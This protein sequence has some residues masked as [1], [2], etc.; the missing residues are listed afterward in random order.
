MLRV[1][2]LLAAAALAAI[3]P[4]LAAQTPAAV[5]LS[6]FA[7]VSYTSSNH[8]VGDVVVG[9]LYDRF[10]DQFMLNAL[11]VVLDK[12]YDASQRSAGFHA[13]AVFGQNASVIQSNGLTLGPQGDLTQLYVT[14]NLPT[15]SG[16]GVQLRAGKIPSLMGLEV[17]ETQANPN[18]SEGLQFIYV[19][20][21]TGLGLAVETK[22]S[23]KV[24]A[25]LR[26]MN[27]WDLV[28]ETNR[29][30][31]FMARIGIYP[32]AQTSIGVLG[33]WGPEQ[34]GNAGDRRSGVEVL[35][36]RKLGKTSLWVQGDFGTEEGIDAQWSALG[37][38]LAQ[39][40]SGTLNVAL[41]ADYL[42]DGD[43]A[44]TSGALGFP[45]NAGHDLYSLTATL[46]V[47]AWP[48]ALV[49]PELRYDHSSLASF[50][51]EQSQVSLGLSIAYLF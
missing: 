6:G 3:V 21:F 30:K 29:G 25:Q 17:I 40:L 51:G 7:E 18:W 9:R 39:D 12:P 47:R 10:H 28:R 34:G 27:G 41:R 19:E 42:H 37:A 44:R 16:N 13:Q 23:D 38:W 31:S 20:N 5:K 49:R 11:G 35:V 36:F 24:D 33:F 22:F 46:N 48:N 15:A 2:R 45:T 26:L 4:T 32:D 1:A 50:D 8:A 43:G 14:L